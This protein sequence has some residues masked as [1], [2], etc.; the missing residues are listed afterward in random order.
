M[1]DYLDEV[2]DETDAPCFS[3]LEQCPE[4]DPISLEPFDANRTIKLRF[5]HLSATEEREITITECYDII[6]LFYYINNIINFNEEQEAIQGS[7]M[8][9]R[10]PGGNILTDGQIKRIIRCYTQ[11]IP[12][13]LE[14]E[15]ETLI[16]WLLATFPGLNETSQAFRSDV[17]HRVNRYLYENR[18]LNLRRFTMNEI[19]SDN[20]ADI[21]RFLQDEF[22]GNRIF[23]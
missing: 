1:A 17:Y 21:T 11:L 20:Q 7:P 19:L 23:V 13:L 18:L 4:I 15:S 5:R 10:S 8:E 3:G 16:D 14:E 12:P 6:S 2:L 9:I 22:P